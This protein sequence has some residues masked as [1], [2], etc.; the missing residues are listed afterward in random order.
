MEEQNNP[1]YTI[2]GLALAVLSAV[3]LTLAF[4]PYNLGFLI[5]IGFIPIL[6]AQYRILPAKLSSLASAIAIGGWLGVVMVPMFGGRS[7]YMAAIPFIVVLVTLVVDKN[8]RTF[9]E[10]TT[11]RWFV[12]EGFLGWVGLEMIRSFVP[13][14]STWFFVGYPLWNQPWLI[15][16]LSVFGIYGLDLLIMLGNYALAFSILVLMENQWKLT[17]PAQNRILTFLIFL[18]VWIGLSLSLYSTPRA[19]APTVRVA[20]VQPNL[21]RAAHLDTT[22]TPEQR[23]TFFAAQT[24]EAAAQG[25]RIIVWPEMSLGFD[26]QVEYTDELQILAGDTQA[27]LV[28]G[29]VVDDDPK[30]F[31]T[32]ATVLAPT[33]EFLGVY[34]KTHPALFSGEPKTVTSG[35]YP[36]YDTSV[37]KLGTMICFDVHFTDVSRRYGSQ[38]AQIIADPSLFGGSIAKPLHPF[39]V[40]RAVENRTTIIMMDV[41][42]HSVIVDPYGRI[43]KLSITPEGSSATLVADVQLGSGNTLYS[44]VGDWLGWLSLAGFVFFAIFISITLRKE[45]MK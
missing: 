9:H 44:K 26:P 10:R 34:G 22:T 11:Y 5:F 21:P 2:L 13:V 36:V 30:G 20:A 25:A 28:I 1:K 18:T 37:G 39:A 17:R 27:N 23:L 4:P 29:Y 40:F 8:K 24:R 31:R 3:L 14:L 32:E 45:N 6:V 42:F 15:Q 41:A 16:P 35:T 19:D 7:F 43:V 12:L 38:G 33:G